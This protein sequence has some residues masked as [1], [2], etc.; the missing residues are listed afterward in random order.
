[1]TQEILSSSP[2]ASAERMIISTF[3]SSDAAE[4]RTSI[5][6]PNTVASGSLSEPINLSVHKK[7]R[8]PYANFSMPPSSPVAT[9][10]YLALSD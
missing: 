9:P 1:M 2:R 8:S 4:L 5:I 7:R 6:P 10:T 3:D